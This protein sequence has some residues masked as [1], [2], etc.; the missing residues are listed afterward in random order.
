M[1]LLNDIFI[2][3]SPDTTTAQQNG[4]QVVNGRIH[5]YVK[6]KVEVAKRTLS[7]QLRPYAP[8]MPYLGSL[9]VRVLWSFDKKSLTRRQQAS[10]KKERP[11]LDNMIKGLA[12]V[13]TK[14]GF[15]GDDSQI[16]RMDLMK[17]WNRKKPGLSIQI[18]QLFDEEDFLEIAENWRDGA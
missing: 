3:G 1:L 5:H 9:Y 4:Q 15:W 2:P 11:D 12:D 17:I 8:D 18:Y 16:V 10:F 7:V 13:M 14:L 6:R